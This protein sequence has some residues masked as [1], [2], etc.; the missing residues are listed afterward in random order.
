M[1]APHRQVEDFTTGTPYRSRTQTLI[2]RSSLRVNS[3]AAHR[4]QRSDQTQ[5]HDHSEDRGGKIFSRESDVHWKPAGG[6]VVEMAGLQQQKPTSSRSPPRRGH[7]RPRP[8]L[9]RTAGAVAGIRQELD[10]Q[11]Y[12]NFA[13]CGV[14]T[15]AQVQALERGASET[16][17]E[18]RSPV[19]VHVD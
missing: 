17:F 8:L 9:P 13:H 10:E 19:C 12:K 18:G 7:E 2:N 11:I 3:R 14:V 6:S 4:K 15:E 16:A 5:A 1:D